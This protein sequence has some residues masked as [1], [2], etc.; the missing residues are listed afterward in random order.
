MRTTRLFFSFM[1]L[2]LLAS[3]TRAQK[4]EGKPNTKN[5]TKMTTQS[6]KTTV[7]SFFT[8][9]GKGDIQG[10]INTFDEASIITAVRTAERTGTQLYGTYNGKDGVQAFIS[11]LGANFNTKT[12][13]I[14]NIVGE[15]DIAFANGKFTH[16]LK[17]TGKI[18]SSDWAL[19]CKVKNGKILEYHFYEDSASFVEA[20]K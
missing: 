9:F 19:M 3:Q 20:A 13:T 14:D 16:E 11:N 8:A 10:L 12:F 5:Q 2:V 1:F 17:A 7:E 18:F 15:G 4:T 6:A